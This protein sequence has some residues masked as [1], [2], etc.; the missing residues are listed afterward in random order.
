MAYSGK[1]N[2]PNNSEMK[3]GIR[4]IKKK[5][6][7]SSSLHILKQITPK[8]HDQKCSMIFKDGLF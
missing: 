6:S 3:K 7:M 8:V 5:L 2:K 1:K 4:F